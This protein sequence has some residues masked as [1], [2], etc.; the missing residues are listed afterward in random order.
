MTSI[1]P[2]GMFSSNTKEPQNG[3]RYDHLLEDGSLAGFSIFYMIIGGVTLVALG[4][5][6][7][8]WL[9]WITTEKKYKLK[10]QR[11]RMFFFLICFFSFPVSTWLINSFRFVKIE[12]AAGI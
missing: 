2:S 8:V 1:H 10:K 9:M 7:F 11:R 6:S 12:E 4:V 5:W 3:S